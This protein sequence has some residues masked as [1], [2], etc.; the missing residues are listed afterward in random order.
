MID[1][2]LI[3]QRIVGTV[4]WQSEVSGFC[5]CPGEALALR[6]AADL[7]GFQPG[8]ERVAAALLQ[9]AFRI[10]RIGFRPDH[11]AL[12]AKPG[13]GAEIEGK[14][15]AHAPDEPLL[16][17]DRLEAVSLFSK[18]VTFDHVEATAERAL[19]C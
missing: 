8:L 19:C 5:R 7:N 10:P 18:H 1:P 6:F 17:F 4:D 11:A 2:R 3:A 9:E 13:G 12:R 16:G 15:R 14:G